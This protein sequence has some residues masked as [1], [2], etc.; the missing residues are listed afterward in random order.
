[1]LNEALVTIRRPTKLLLGVHNPSSRSVLIPRDTK[2]GRLEK[3]ASVVSVDA[4]VQSD[5]SF[6]QPT[7]KNRIAPQVFLGSLKLSEIEKKQVT[8][9]L[10]RNDDMFAR[11]DDDMGYLS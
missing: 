5:W 6:Q 11:N 8:N 7:G 1:M 3:T 2:L 9:V 10:A 4:N